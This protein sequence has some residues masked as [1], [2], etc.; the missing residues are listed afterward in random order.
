MDDERMVMI[1]TTADNRQFIDGMVA[2]LVE[3]RLVACAQVSGPVTST[4]W[5]RGRI[6][7]TEEW[8]CTMKTRASLY[9]DVEA[10]IRADHPYEVPEII[11]LDI[12][13]ALP[14][15]Y[16]WVMRETELK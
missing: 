6:E 11:C 15:Y 3:M 1:V 7:G 10:Q 13:T 12:E 2:R 14:E 4:Y 16:L 9:A 5:W 8:V